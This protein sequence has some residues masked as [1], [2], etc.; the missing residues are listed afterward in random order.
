MKLTLKTVTISIDTEIKSLFHQRYNTNTKC[1]T[2]TGYDLNQVNLYINKL[3]EN[4]GSIVFEEIEEEERYKFLITGV[5][6]CLGERLEFNQVS[7]FTAACGWSPSFQILCKRTAVGCVFYL[8]YFG[9]TQIPCI[10]VWNRYIVLNRI[11]AYLL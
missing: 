2:H 9:G 11:Y 3:F 10:F 1:L 5:T 7:T 4:V 6:S 8:A